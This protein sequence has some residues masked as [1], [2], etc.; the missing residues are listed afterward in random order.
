MCQGFDNPPHPQGL[1]QP[2]A[3]QHVAPLVVGGGNG[4]NALV[5]EAPHALGVLAAVDLLLAAL[6]PER[7]I[8][9]GWSHS[10]CN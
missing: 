10:S 5:D 2:P 3:L 6:A 4:V 7:R 8:C 1:R 9:S